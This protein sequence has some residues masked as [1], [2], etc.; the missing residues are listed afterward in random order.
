MHAHNPFPQVAHN[1]PE[2]IFKEF[3]DI[4]TGPT[5]AQ[6]DNLAKGLG[7]TAPAEHKQ[8]WAWERGENA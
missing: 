4:R 1:R 7:F 8:V 2:A 6:L 5:D 3:I